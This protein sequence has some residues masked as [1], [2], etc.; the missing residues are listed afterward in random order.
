MG[1]VYAALDDLDTPFKEMYGIRGEERRITTAARLAKAQL[2]KIGLG[3]EFAKAIDALGYCRRIRNQFAHCQWWNAFDGCVNFVALE[4]FVKEKIGT[5]SK[6]VTFGDFQRRGASLQLLN[7]QLSF[8]GY[9]LKLLAFVEGEAWHHQGSK[10]HR[11]YAR[12]VAPPRPELSEPA[13]PV[14]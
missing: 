5:N 6:V 4:E 2:G 11:R 8:F 3:S 12:P 14:L 10:M 1:C 7:D 9:V 13:R